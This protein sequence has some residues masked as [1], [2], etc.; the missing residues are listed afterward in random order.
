MSPTGIGS[1]R[2]RMSVITRDAHGRR[3]LWCKGAP[4]TVLPL[5][6]SWLDGGI[7]RPF[8]ATMRRR[9][10]QAQADMAD[11]GLRVLALAWRPL[12]G[13]ALAQEG[14]LQL[15]G[16][17][18]LEDP[19]RAD[20]HE[21]VTRC[22]E[23]GLRVIMVTGDHPRTALAIAREIALVQGTSPSVVLGDEVRRMSASEL[24]LALDA[25]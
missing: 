23:A 14:D 25:P 20:V 13:D 12:A 2:R 11:R 6:T 19:P 9:F 1:E 3:N 7:A 5:C 18:G 10:E 21:A 15:C 16:L 22:H 8:D 4:E 24:Q 17:V